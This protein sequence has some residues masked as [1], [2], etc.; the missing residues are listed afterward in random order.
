MRFL[1]FLNRNKSVVVS[2]TI[3]TSKLDMS[4]P[5]CGQMDYRKM[6]NPNVRESNRHVVM[7]C[8]CNNCG[9]YFKKIFEFKEIIHEGQEQNCSKV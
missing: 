3:T 5:K 1:K 6:F 9:L 7:G 2:R 8:K 4:C